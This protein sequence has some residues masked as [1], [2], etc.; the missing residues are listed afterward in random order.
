[1]QWELAK[2]SM[3]VMN[4]KCFPTL[5]SGMIPLADHYEVALLDQ[6]ASKAKLSVMWV[7]FH[8]DLTLYQSS[9]FTPLLSFQQNERKRKGGLREH[10]TLGFYLSIILKSY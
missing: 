7:I 2:Y 4:A 10:H 9:L 3:C 5:P 6:V 8:Q 1:M